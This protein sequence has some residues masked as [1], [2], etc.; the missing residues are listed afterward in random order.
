PGDELRAADV[1]DPAK[2]LAVPPTITGLDDPRR[3]DP[4]V[5][6]TGHVHRGERSF[7]RIGSLR[8]GM[9]HDPCE[10]SVFIKSPLPTEPPERFGTVLDDLPEVSDRKH[11]SRQRWK[12]LA[13]IGEPQIAVE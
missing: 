10:G 8:E 9:E 6:W 2:I 1:T 7:H 11:L 12:N 5:G 13:G 4:G 3:H